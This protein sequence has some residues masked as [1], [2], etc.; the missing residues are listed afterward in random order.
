MALQHRKL[1]SSLWKAGSG[2][3]I[4]GTLSTESL[5]LCPAPPSAL[6]TFTVTFSGDSGGVS[7]W[8]GSPPGDC[9]HSVTSAGREHGASS[10]QLL[11]DSSRRWAAR[12]RFLCARGSVVNHAGHKQP[13]VAHPYKPQLVSG[14]L[15]TFLE[16][17]DACPDWVRLQRPHLESK[18]ALHG[19]VAHSQLPLPASTCSYRYPGHMWST[20]CTGTHQGAGS[21]QSSHSAKMH[22]ANTMPGTGA[23]SVAFPEH[24]LC[25]CS[26]GGIRQWI[27]LHP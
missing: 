17:T 3:V 6:L 24:W 5:S 4:K 7:G 21:L 2:E 11:G 25:L 9:Q 10:R 23:S 13:V 15:L 14:H 27:I 22:S 26:M 8:Q 12:H 19:S 20:E 1:D 16:G 18:R